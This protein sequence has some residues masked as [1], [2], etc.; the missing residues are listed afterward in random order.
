MTMREA[1]DL[2]L[3]R[4]RVFVDTPDAL[5]EGGDVAQ[6]IRAG[7]ITKSAVVADLAALARG[8]PGRGGEDEI[9]LFKSV[10]ASIE[11]LAAASLVWRRAGQA[12]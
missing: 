6:A 7:S 12:A 1:D 10:G 8:A 3:Q 5:E 4:A 11:D 9:T 2:A